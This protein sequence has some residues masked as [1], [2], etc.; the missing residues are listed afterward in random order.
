MKSAHHL[1]TLVVYLHLQQ[2]DLFVVGDAVVAPVVVAF[3]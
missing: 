2:I 1:D 3:H